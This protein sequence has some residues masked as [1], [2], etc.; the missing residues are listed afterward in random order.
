MDKKINKITEEFTLKLF[1]RGS[2]TKNF[3]ILKNLP[4]TII[5]I[6]KKLDITKMPANK[7]VNELE[8]VGLVK[9]KKKEGIIEQTGLTNPFIKTIE[10]IQ[11]GVNK[12]LSSL[13]ELSL[14]G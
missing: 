4:T 12:E 14:K 5:K 11:K 3:N 7:R 1:R 13:I 6:S 9:R 2:D 8:E 10:S